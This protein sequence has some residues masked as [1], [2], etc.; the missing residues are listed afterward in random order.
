VANNDTPAKILQKSLEKGYHIPEISEEDQDRNLTW[1]EQHLLGMTYGEIRDASVAS[2]DL[3]TLNDVKV[4]VQWAI[5][6]SASQLT[7]DETVEKLK[8]IVSKSSS[9][10]WSE[11][12]RIQE[13]L[14]ANNYQGIPEKETTEEYDA[15]GKL[16]RR[17]VRNRTKNPTSDIAAMVKT[18]KDLSAFEA[19]LSGIGNR[20]S[21]DKI[22]KVKVSVLHDMV[23]A[24][25]DERRRWRHE[26]LN[27]MV[28][29]VAATGNDSVGFNDALEKLREKFL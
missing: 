4:G 23:S 1:F 20:E 22:N 19:L 17:I 29:Y 7:K 25:T 16:K 8:T 9:I 28:I 3:V 18:L 2:G 5:R 14:R 26:L 27:F 24:S 21:D 11:Y 6:M 13:L 15:D 10:V 12:Q